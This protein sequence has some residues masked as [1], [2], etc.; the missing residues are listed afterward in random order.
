[1]S[2]ADTVVAALDAYDASA[3]D[4]TRLR[5]ALDA[6]RACRAPQLGELVAR[7]D[8]A[9]DAKPTR[10]PNGAAFRSHPEWLRP[11]LDRIRHARR[12]P[13]CEFEL[14]FILHEPPDPR[15]A[16]WALDQLADPP[17]ISLP[18]LPFW[19]AVIRLFAHCRDPGHD[20]RLASLRAL[21]DTRLHAPLAERLRARLAEL[22]SRCVADPLSR[23]LKD[24]IVERARGYRPSHVVKMAR[25]LL[26]EIHA[27]PDD[28]GAR[29]VLADL[30]I[31]QGDPRGE[32][33][34]LQLSDGDTAA[35]EAA[36][37]EAHWREWA[38]PL[39]TMMKRSALGFQNGFLHSVRL[40]G[41]RPV[42]FYQHRRAPVWQTVRHIDARPR[43]SAGWLFEVVHEKT[44]QARLRVISGCSFDVFANL[45]GYPWDTHIEVIDFG[46]HAAPSVDEMLARD[47]DAL[48][49]APGLRRLHT[50]TL[51]WRAATVDAERWFMR[52]AL[53]RRLRCLTLRAAPSALPRLVRSLEIG[54]LERFTLGDEQGSITLHRRDGAWGWPMI[55]A[56]PAID[57]AA[58][59]AV[60]HCAPGWSGPTTVVG[61]D[62]GEVSRVRAALG[63]LIG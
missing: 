56:G 2:A 60:Q 22:P 39:S 9:L 53:A 23:A 32:F 52:T 35:R 29:A 24:R 62:A 16:T 27:D 59:E 58:I 11:I 6:W 21:P 61:E 36:L 54:Q 63:R 5:C 44:I 46:H 20:T 57:A 28:L 26:A 4:V 1:M 25:A 3:D 33:I 34:A 13:F 40:Q 31:R 48:R 30:L 14:S 50:L 38:Y 7:I 43:H 12:T 51:G 41:S 8:L 19:E 42:A 45:A 55:E 18:T 49:H 17:L 37:L 47:R 15:C 10:Q